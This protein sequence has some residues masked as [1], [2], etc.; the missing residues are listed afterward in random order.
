M[1]EE[2]EKRVI[3]V[4]DVRTLN[5]LYTNDIKGEAEQMAYLATVVKQIRAAEPLTILLDSGNWSKGTLLSDQFKGM[6]MVEIMSH[7]KYD[8]V[9][10]GEGEIEFGSQNLYTLEGE[11]KFPLLCINLV[12]TG[13]GI[14]PYFLDKK[15]IML[16]RGPFNVAVTAVASPGKYP[17][18]GLEVKEP[19]A[20]LPGILEEIEKHN[21]D[22]II[23][24]SRM[25]LDRD[26]ALARAF[27]QL[28]V[29]V[30][31]GDCIN[32]ETPHV[33]GQTFIVQAGEKAQFLGSLALDMQTTI[34]ITAVE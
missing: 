11:A 32:M 27:P 29:I 5:L 9:G 30:G 14:E 26:K 20:I 6:P 18:A 28:N 19:F 8:A 1:T 25:G 23:L 4:P 2:S 13:T 31:G 22:I 15:F 3:E 21:P 10:I 17:G 12:E 7:L 33:E 34:K 16:E 24:L